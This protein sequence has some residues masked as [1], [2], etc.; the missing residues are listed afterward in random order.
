[1]SQPTI[2]DQALNAEAARYIAKGYAV[3]A[4]TPGQVVLVKKK[5][6]GLLLNVLL[7]IITGGLWLIWIA[8]RLINRKADRVVLYVDASGRVK[9]R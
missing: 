6:V 7:T 4:T 9:Q 2:A 1:M 3:E 8:Y 5:R